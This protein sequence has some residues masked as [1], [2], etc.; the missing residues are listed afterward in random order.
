[1]K[2]TQKRKKV[3]LCGIDYQHEIGEAPDGVRIYPSVE[4]FRKHAKCRDCG[5]VEMEISFNKWVEAQDLK[6]MFAN[7][8][9]PNEAQRLQIIAVEDEIKQLEQFRDRMKKELAEFE[10]RSKSVKI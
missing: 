4:A 7:K 8:I 5:I 1:M 2:K 9:P 10:K 3:Y 6:K